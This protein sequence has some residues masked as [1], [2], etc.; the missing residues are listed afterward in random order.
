M[1]KIKN[2]SFEWYNEYEST[3]FESTNFNEY[4]LFQQPFAHIFICSI[5]DEIQD[6][7]FLKK[8]ENIPLIIYEG[9]YEIKMPTMIIVLNDCSAE[10]LITHDVVLKKFDL[11]CSYNNQFYSLCCDINSN[12]DN[13]AMADI[14]V[15]YLQ[16]LDVYSNP[17]VSQER[18]ALISKE[19]RDNFKTSIFK[20]FNEFIKP[21]LQKMAMELDEDI[22]NNKK[23]LKNRFLSVF[24][25]S[26][27]IEYV[28][29][30]NIYKVEF[31]FYLACDD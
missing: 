19:E 29:G 22:T 9:I 23:G 1:C 15:K 4:E 27:K 10:N 17:E 24:G 7:E 5:N 26:D 6:I 31:I 20:F 14:W 8:R 30:F 13:T 18:G 11:I 12:K 3:L 16:K 2:N 25:K 21:H 28:N